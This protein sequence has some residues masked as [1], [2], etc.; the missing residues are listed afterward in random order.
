[1]ELVQVA[2]QQ[3]DDDTTLELEQLL[4]E[5]NKQLKGGNIKQATL[6][7]DELVVLMEKNGFEYNSDESSSWQ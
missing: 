3:Q 4:L 5:M 6:L 7:G 2:G 1:L